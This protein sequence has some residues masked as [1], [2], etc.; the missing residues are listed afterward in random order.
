[1]GLRISS[2]GT[3]Y[4]EIG[5]AHFHVYENLRVTTLEAE[6]RLY[7]PK[8]KAAINN[9]RVGKLRDACVMLL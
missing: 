1:M 5:L 4:S 8:R 9:I 7:S 2:Q 6:I 3:I